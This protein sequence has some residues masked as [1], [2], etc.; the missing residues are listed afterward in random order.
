M[1][2]HAFNINNCGIKSSGSSG[3]DTKEDLEFLEVAEFTV[4][5]RNIRVD[6]HMVHPWNMSI[7]ALEN[8]LLDSSCAT[9]ISASWT[10]RQPSSQ[11]SATTSS[12]RKQQSRGTRHPSWIKTIS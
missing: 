2:I 3:K 6:M 5:L 1:S 4:A 10:S 12:R 7:V 8:F 11:G 9:A